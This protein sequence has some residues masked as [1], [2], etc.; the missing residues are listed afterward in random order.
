MEIIFGAGR[1]HL[2][3]PITDGKA[4]RQGFIAHTPEL[5]SVEIQ[6]GTYCRNNPGEMTVAVH[7]P[8]DNSLVA[9]ARVMV[10]DFVDNTFHK[11]NLNCELIPGRTYEL[12]IFTLDC[13]SGMSVTAKYCRKRYNFHLFIGARLIK[14][15]ELTCKFNYEGRQL[16]VATNEPE[17]IHREVKAAEPEV[18]PTGFT[19]GLVS[20]VIPH[21][22]CQQLLTKCLASLTKQTYNAIEVIVVDDGSEQAGW[23][24]AIVDA[25]KPLLATTF[26]PFG[27]NM[28]APAARNRGAKYVSG[29]YLIF[30]DADIEMYPDTFEVFVNALMDN[31]AVDFVYGGFRWGNEIVAPVDWDADKLM[32]RNF[33]STM[34]MMRRAKFPGWDERLLRHQDWDLWLTMAK[35]GSQGICTGELM[36]ET[37]KREGSISTDGNIDIMKSI[38]IVRRKHG[39]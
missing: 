23:T 21:L 26:L 24:Q 7:D 17:L 3:G 12:R 14:D 38:D 25:Y 20:V 1:S 13:R 10:A 22:N 33:I 31:L 16:A 15:G 19:P 2:T 30:V 9:K 4:I 36:F 5:E 18:Q 11:F 34:S 32:G 6:F 35:N 8:R 39:L 37:P 27:R 29:E 28:G